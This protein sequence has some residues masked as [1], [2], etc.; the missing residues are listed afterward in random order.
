[1][2]WG[3][4]AARRVVAPLASLQNAEEITG[5]GSLRRP[6]RYG[7]LSLQ[8]FKQLCDYQQLPNWVGYFHS[9]LS[10]VWSQDG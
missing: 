10:L 8:F 5:P 1:M 7:A 3:R 4:V 2:P 9:C 6:H